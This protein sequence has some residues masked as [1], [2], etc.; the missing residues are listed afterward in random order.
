MEERPTRGRATRPEDAPSRDSNARRN[1][2]WRREERF[3]QYVR[4]LTSTG[5]YGMAGRRGRPVDSMVRLDGYRD[6]APF[7]DASPRH[8][9]LDEIAAG[10]QA[11]LAVG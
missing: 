4:G 2:P 3:T 8:A 11:Q 5:V 10:P 1:R 9:P 6:A 7:A